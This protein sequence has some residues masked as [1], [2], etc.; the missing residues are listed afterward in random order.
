VSAARRRFAARSGQPT[1]VGLLGLVLATC[2]GLLLPGFALAFVPN[3]DDGCSF[4]APQ[5]PGDPLSVVAFLDLCH[6]WTLAGGSVLHTAAFG[7]AALPSGEP[8]PQGLAWTV[9]LVGRPP[10][11]GA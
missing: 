1:L 2:A 3:D 6:G 7:L 5:P 4:Q 9:A 8:A 10:P 11:P